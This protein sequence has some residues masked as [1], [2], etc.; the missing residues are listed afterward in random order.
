[1]TI[2]FASSGFGLAIILPI[3]IR[4]FSAKW[5]VVVSMG[6]SVVTWL[7]AGMAQEGIQLIIV[8]CSFPLNGLYFP[9]LRTTI[10]G[11]FGPERHS[12]ALGAVATLQQVTQ[13]I[14]PPAFTKIYGETLNLN[15]TIPYLAPNNFGPRLSFAYLCSAFSVSACAMK[16]TLQYT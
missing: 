11:I 4:I 5:A 12:L 13:T 16:Q 15:A 7:A 10:A 6:A 14:A 3:L 9:V 1:M 2:M 8:M